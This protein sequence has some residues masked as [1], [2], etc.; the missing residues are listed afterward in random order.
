MT[1]ECVLFKSVMRKLQ[2]E[3]ISSAPQK[4]SNCVTCPYQ[5]VAYGR[6]KNIKCVCV[7]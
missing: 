3:L 1:H 2:F 4:L 7:W 6:I 5:R